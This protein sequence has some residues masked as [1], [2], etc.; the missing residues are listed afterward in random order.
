MLN[1]ISKSQ[2]IFPNLKKATNMSHYPNLNSILH[3][4]AYIDDEQSVFVIEEDGEN[5]ESPIFEA[6]DDNDGDSNDERWQQNPLNTLQPDHPIN[7]DANG[8]GRLSDDESIIVERSN[9]H[10]V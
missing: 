10:P 8:G 9:T 5:D 7:G 2:I 3:A 1:Q 6:K 4:A